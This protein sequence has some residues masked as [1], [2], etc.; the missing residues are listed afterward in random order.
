LISRRYT[1]AMEQARL[2]FEDRDFD[3]ATV[4]AT[5]ALNYKSGDESAIRLK[6]ES[7]GLARLNQGERL[8][9]RGDYAEAIKVLNAA[10]PSLSNTAHAESLL[11]V[12]TKREQERI[13]AETK[14][15]AELVEQENQ[16]RRQQAATAMR[17]VRV[18]FLQDTFA[19][20]CQKL[21]NHQMYAEHELIST[22]T[23]K[24]IA[25]P[26]NNAMGLESPKFDVIKYEWPSENIFVSVSSQSVAGGTRMCVI[27]ASEVQTNE[28]H[29]RFK[30]FEYDNP[31]DMKLLG[32][33][34]RVT[35][36]ITTTATPS[37]AELN[38]R[39]EKTATRAKEGIKTVRDRIR[40][41]AGIPAVAK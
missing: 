35:A 8:G 30:V 4:A 29:I 40:S 27:V 13:D 26:I 41:A 36:Q 33:L 7:T 38:A 9:E 21:P 2:F 3:R 12:F 18:A 20:W 17:T 28:T 24:D 11:A 1:L 39:A 10:I 6:R 5:E 15:Q 22:N 16:R 23:V 19:V 34:I 14:R 32:G 37:A 31:P 25:T